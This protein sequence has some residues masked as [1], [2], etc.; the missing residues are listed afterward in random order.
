MVTSCGILFGKATERRESKSLPS[1]QPHV[2]M[3]F[4]DIL[5]SFETKNFFIYFKRACIVFTKTQNLNILCNSFHSF[6]I[7][8]ASIATKNFSSHIVLEQFALEYLENSKKNGQI[9]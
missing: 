9:I 7:G 2:S 6:I 1:F 5:S 8:Q 4:P 3:F